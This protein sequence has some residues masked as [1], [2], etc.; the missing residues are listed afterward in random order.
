METTAAQPRDIE[1]VLLTGSSGAGRSTAAR[2]MEDLGYYVVDNLPP[3]MIPEVVRLAAEGSTIERVAIVTDV[4][5]RVF[6]GGT[7]TLINMLAERGVRPTIVFLSASEDIL[8]RR[9]ENVRRAHPLQGDGT[10]LDGIAAEREMIEP[11]R[12]LADLLVD[13]SDLSVHDLRRRLEEVFDTPVG[14]QVRITVQSFGFKYGLP[15][16]ADM[17][18]DARY[19]PNP[20]WD[21]DLRPYN[22]TDAKVSDYVL[23]QDGAS[24]AL[25]HL[26]ALVDTVIP[27]Y[28]RE[29]KRYL[30]IA[31][32]CTG[33][34]HRSVAMARELGS[35]LAGPDIDVRVV[36]RDL[37]RE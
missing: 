4:R 25:D 8:V 17:V 18:F 24:E 27:G 1:V 33:G 37:G 21:P 10:I 32:G 31:V 30:T 6:P 19:L 7:V 11:L 16:D 2:V 26:D 20:H 34:K 29:G 35:R 28:R 23:A 36:H 9:F 12:G 3:T 5:S 22:G 14:R 15:R 13:T